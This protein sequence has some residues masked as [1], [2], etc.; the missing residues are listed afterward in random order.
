MFFLF[1]QPGPNLHEPATFTR[2]EAHAPL[3]GRGDGNPLHE[4]WNLGDRWA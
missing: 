1:F 2:E 4:R 3:A